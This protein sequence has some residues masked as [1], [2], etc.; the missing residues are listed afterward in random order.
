M[1]RILLFLFLA[2]SFLQAKISDYL[3]LPNDTA[4]IDE[5]GILRASTAGA[6][7]EILLKFDE[8]STN[9]IMVVTL[10]TLGDYSIEEVANEQARALG[11]GQKGYDNGVLLLVA[12]NE[13]RV[14]IEVGYGLEGVL[15]DGVSKRIIEYKILPHFRA[16]DF[17][18]GIVS[19]VLTILDFIE[20][21][22]IKF[23]KIERAQGE[24][25]D[26]DFIIFML[27]FFFVFFMMMRNK[28]RS[29]G[30]YGNTIILGDGLDEILRGGFGSSGGFGGGF[31]TGSRGGFGGGSG[32]FGRSSRG[33]GFRGGGGGF[34]GGGASGG[35]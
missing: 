5:A 24:E 9:Q 12:P 26:I 16:G 1:R 13:R 6:L 20:S 4:I 10:K 34:G 21:G 35:W 28:S 2:L 17:E 18:G 33:G 31:G 25:I 29:H 27:F 22:D 19:G 8:N 23:A 11:I 32:G 14:R 7:N 30:D 15:T 3:A